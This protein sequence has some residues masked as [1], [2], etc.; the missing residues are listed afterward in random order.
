M[1]RPGADLEEKHEP[2]GLHLPTPVQT[3][4][5]K[6]NEVRLLLTSAAI[7]KRSFTAFTHRILREHAFDGW[8]M[9]VAAIA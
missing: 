2:L 3:Q 7:E 8:R 4:E 9:S 5:K 6:R 1:R